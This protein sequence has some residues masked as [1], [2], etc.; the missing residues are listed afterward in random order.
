MEINCLQRRE[1]YTQTEMSY[2]REYYRISSH[3][4]RRVSGAARGRTFNVTLFWRRSINAVAV[5][6]SE[7]GL[8]LLKVY[9]VCMSSP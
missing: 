2:S 8:D 1:M 6:P 4:T 5:T 7:V 3:P 9:A